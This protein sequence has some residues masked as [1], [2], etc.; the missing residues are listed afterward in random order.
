MHFVVKSNFSSLDPVS[1]KSWLVLQQFTQQKLKVK[2]ETSTFTFLQNKLSQPR[3]E[4]LKGGLL[5]SAS[6]LL[7]P[8]LPSPPVLCSSFPPGSSLPANASQLE[9]NWMD[10]LMGTPT[11][12]QALWFQEERQRGAP[13]RASATRDVQSREQDGRGTSN[14]VKVAW[15]G[16]RQSSSCWW[17]C[18]GSGWWPTW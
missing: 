13:L 6:L 8:L 5:R 16:R 4:F 14:L 11:G 1:S 10:T 3:L 15:D 12:R 2:S 18:W 7:T 9:P 17:W